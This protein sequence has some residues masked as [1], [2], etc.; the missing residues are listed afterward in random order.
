M[1]PCQVS[2][3]AAGTPASAMVG[4]PGSSGQRSRLVTARPLRAPASMSGIATATDMAAT[5]TVRV[6]IAWAAGAA[7]G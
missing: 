1:M 2:A 3:E 7:P 4:T 5:S 6:R